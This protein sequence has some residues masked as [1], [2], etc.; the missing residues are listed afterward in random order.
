MTTVVV[1][2][3][4]ANK[5]RHGGSA[6]V[7]TSW[8]EGLRELGFDVVLVEQLDAAACTDAR[9][10]ACSFETAPATAHFARVA[11]EFG[12][13]GRSALIAPDG[14]RT[15][16]LGLEELNDLIAG[17]DLLVNLGGHLRPGDLTRGIP[18]R[19]YVDL[20]PGYTQIWLA[21]GHDLGIEDHHLH[22]TVG[23]NVGTPSSPL[24]AGGV[25]W[26]PIRQPVV[27]DRWPVSDDAFTSCTTIA[28]WRGAFGRVE[29]DGRLYGQKA[30]EFR[31]LADLP[32]RA[33]VPCEVVLDVHAQDASDAAR[34]R[35]GG[36][37]VADPQLVET[38][39]AFSAYVRGSGAEISPAQGVYVGARTGWFS[40]RTVRYL[41]SGRPA[42]V[43]DTGLGASL[44]TGE[45]LVTFTTP[46]QA[47]AGLR[48]VFE[49]HARH[50]DAARAIAEQHFAHPRALAP[51]LDAAGVAP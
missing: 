17:A 9:G 42:V 11:A 12:F 27:L 39:A 7:R 26:R 2:G 32:R 20:D 4:I 41:A 38:T 34:L 8:A 46:E 24:P 16:G 49:D 5:Y 15:A 36:W 23:V 47:A 18:M 10:A 37:T 43:Q 30:H 22:F 3:A 33:G 31:R 1:A 19:V 44:P 6:W 13:A 40:D 29:W 35:D 28:S 51:L 45:G 50:A 14:T 48:A 21:D 25:R